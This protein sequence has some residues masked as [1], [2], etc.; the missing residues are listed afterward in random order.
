[1]P[2]SDI[3]KC[4]KIKQKEA[5]PFY[6]GRRTSQTFVEKGIECGKQ[7]AKPGYSNRKC[8]YLWSVD[9]QDELLTDV[10]LLSV[11]ALA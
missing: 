8:F 4:L 7:V 1:M 9:F 5:L 6:G 3:C 11:S 2:T 10:L